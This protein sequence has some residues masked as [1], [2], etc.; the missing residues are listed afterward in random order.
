MGLNTAAFV[1]EAAL[2]RAEYEAF[3][4]LAPL[5][6]GKTEAELNELCDRLAAHIEKAAQPE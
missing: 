1:G 4:P 2:K 3:G 5:A 6:V